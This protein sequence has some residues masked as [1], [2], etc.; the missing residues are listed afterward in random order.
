VQKKGAGV[1]WGEISLTGEWS[2]SLMS[3]GEGVG[4][5]EDSDLSPDWGGEGKDA[6]KRVQR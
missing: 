1:D 6:L 3:R 5:S 2:S 4:G